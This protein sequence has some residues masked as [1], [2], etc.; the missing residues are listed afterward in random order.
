[1]N[2]LEDQLDK[3]KECGIVGLVKMPDGSKKYFA[4]KLDRACFIGGV[5]KD[6]DYDYEHLRVVTEDLITQLRFSQE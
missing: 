1:M 3:F 6:L 4:V 5:G 2:R